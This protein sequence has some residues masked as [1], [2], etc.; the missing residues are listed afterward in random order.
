[1]LRLFFIT[2]HSVF[3]DSTQAGRDA[4]NKEG[5]FYLPSSHM[6]THFGETQKYICD[7]TSIPVP[8]SYQSTRELKYGQFWVRSCYPMYYKYIIES[9]RGTHCQ[10]TEEDQVQFDAAQDQQAKK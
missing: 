2:I 9:L 4:N 3:P 10:L 8:T 6:Q 7:D 1:M 5:Q